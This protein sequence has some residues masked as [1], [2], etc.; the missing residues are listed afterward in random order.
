MP[1]CTPEVI[2][3]RAERHHDFFQRGVAGPFADPVDGAFHLAR[4]VADA[5]ERVGHRQ[6]EIVV[7]VH[8]DDGPLDVRHVLPNATGSARRTAPARRSRWCREY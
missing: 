4:A 5:G 2:G 8:A 7:A 1:V 3:A 6:A